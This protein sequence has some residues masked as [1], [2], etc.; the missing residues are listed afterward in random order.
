RQTDPHGGLLEQGHRQQ[1]YPEASPDRPNGRGR[2]GCGA[3]RAEGG[4][5]HASEHICRSVSERAQEPTPGSAASAP[6]MRARCGRFGLMK[7]LGLTGGLASGKS[8]VS[9]VFVNLGAEGVDAGQL[10]CEDW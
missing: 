8:T 3:R 2:L 4:D 1:S 6:K 10:A 7:V 5:E 9:R